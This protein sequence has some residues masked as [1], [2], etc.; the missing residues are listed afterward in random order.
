M[1]QELYNLKPANKSQFA[2]DDYQ[3]V[4]YIWGSAQLIGDFSTFIALNCSETLLH[5]GLGSTK[6]ICSICLM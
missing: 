5:Y 4:P 3:F 2:I 6:L 1:L